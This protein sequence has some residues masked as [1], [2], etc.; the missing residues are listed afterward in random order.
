MVVARLF[1]G[2]SDG[3]DV[4]RWMGGEREDELGRVREEQVRAW[5]GGRRGANP[6]KGGGGMG[7]HERPI[8][9]PCVP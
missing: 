9:C 1:N 8:L 6:V 2:C 5:Q 4:T 7:G 3:S